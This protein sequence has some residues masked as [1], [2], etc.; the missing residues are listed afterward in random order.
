MEMLLSI[1]TYQGSVQ[2]FLGTASEMLVRILGFGEERAE[3]N[4]ANPSETPE[5]IRNP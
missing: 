2:M 1:C 4:L 5:G 3:E